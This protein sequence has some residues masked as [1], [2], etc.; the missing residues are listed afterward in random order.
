MDIAAW[1]DSIE[2]IHEDFYEEI[3][4]AADCGPFDGGCVVTAEALQR[5]IGGEIMVLIRPNDQADHAV[6]LK[7]DQLWDFDGPLPPVA[8]IQRFNATEL[9]G[10]PFQCVGYRPIRAIDLH[11]AYRGDE[12]VERLEALFRQ[13]LEPQLSPAP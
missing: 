5:V 13:A 8:F 10:M 11:K 7:D 6:V 3:V 1:N 12:L 4:L 9:S 2:S